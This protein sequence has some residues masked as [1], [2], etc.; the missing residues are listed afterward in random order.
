MAI[1]TKNVFSNNLNKYLDLSKINRNDPSRR[2][3]SESHFQNS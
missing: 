3:L 2:K 1:N